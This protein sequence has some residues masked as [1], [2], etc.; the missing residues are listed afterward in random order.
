MG[1]PSEIVYNIVR[2]SIYHLSLKSL[3]AYQYSVVINKNVFKK[4]IIL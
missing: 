2:Y 1:H 4:N 3:Y